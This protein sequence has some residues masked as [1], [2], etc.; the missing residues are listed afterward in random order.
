MNLLAQFR[1]VK[2]IIKRFGLSYD[3]LSSFSAANA[4]VNCG[5]RNLSTSINSMTM[6]LLLKLTVVPIHNCCKHA[7]HASEVL[8]IDTETVILK[9]LSPFS[10]F[11]KRKKPLL[12]LF[13]FVYCEYSLL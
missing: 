6:I 7:K 2:E 1:C 5:R 3:N 8:D 12:S 13:K 11:A 4:N 10:P 9:T